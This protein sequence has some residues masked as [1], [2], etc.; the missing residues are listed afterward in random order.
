MSGGQD[1]EGDEHDDRVVDGLGAGRPGDLAQLG[2]DLRTNCRGRGPLLLGPGWAGGGLAALRLGLAVGAELRLGAG[3]SASSLGSSPCV[4]NLGDGAGR[5]WTG[6][7]AG[8]TR[9]PNLRFWR[10][11]LYQLSYCPSGERPARPLAP[12]AG[13]LGQRAVSRRDV[14]QPARRQAARRERVASTMRRRRRRP[15][16]P[17]RGRRGRRPAGRSSERPDGVALARRL[18]VGEDLGEQ[19]RGR[20]E[21]LGAQGPQRAAA[22]CGTGPA[23]PGSAGTARR[24]GGRRRRATTAPSAVAGEH[25]RRRRH[26][27]RACSSSLLVARRPR[28]QPSARSLRRAR[29]SRTLA[30]DSEMPSSAA[31]ASWGR[32]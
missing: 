7:R 10:P 3:A 14:G 25:R 23:R 19:A 15:R 1:D 9:T 8:G 24:G 30:A 32:S 12:R 22:A 27:A 18:D 17:P 21:H 16:W 5:D 4:G 13:R 28:E 20:L 31:I 6:S 2:P 29:C 26:T 11:L